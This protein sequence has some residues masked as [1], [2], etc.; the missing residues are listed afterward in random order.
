MLHLR[1]V[2]HLALLLH[3]SVIHT[4]VVSL[5]LD[6]ERSSFYP[7]RQ[8]RRVTMY[9]IMQINGKNEEGL[10]RGRRKEANRQIKDG[11]A[12]LYFFFARA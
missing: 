8:A 3:L 11:I 9:I 4:D 1:L 10:G 2:L 7:Q 12:V 6:R 5:A